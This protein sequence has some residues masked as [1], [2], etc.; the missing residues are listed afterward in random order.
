MEQSQT[1]SEDHPDW[2]RFKALYR[3]MRL[4]GADIGKAALKYYKENHRG[5]HAAKDLTKGEKIMSIP[6]CL[7]PT[8]QI[9]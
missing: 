3:W 1:F 4:G 8:L 9:A 6:H 7:F 5:I 2:E